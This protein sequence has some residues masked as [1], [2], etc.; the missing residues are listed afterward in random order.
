M[1]G[2]VTFK[3]DRFELITGTLINSHSKPRNFL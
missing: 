2:A 1:H 3:C